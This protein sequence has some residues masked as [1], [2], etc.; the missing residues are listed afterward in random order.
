MLV[1]AAAPEGPLR[2]SGEFAVAGRDT[3]LALSPD[4]NRLV[5]RRLGDGGEPRYWVHDLGQS[6]AVR[7]A[8]P[9]FAAA[10]GAVW[11]LDATFLA[12]PC[13]VETGGG[14]E[15]R[16]ALAAVDGS[17]CGHLATVARF[18][19]GPGRVAWLPGGPLAFVGSCRPMTWD[20]YL[21]W[22]TSGEEWLAVPGVLAD[23][24]AVH[25]EGRR[26]AYS[27]AIRP[28]RVEI[29]DLAT[30][31][32]VEVG[33]YG[34]GVTAALWSPDGGRLAVV[35]R[36]HGSDLAAVS[37]YEAGSG[38]LVAGTGEIAWVDP[39]AGNQV[40]WSAGGRHV[41]LV[42]GVESGQPPKAIYRVDG[43]TGEVTTWLDLTGG[44]G[45]DRLRD[46]RATL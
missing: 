38:V 16:I 4:G 12:I 8:L 35:H 11:S 34:A 22:V 40:A 44:E 41:F 29:A 26:V 5:T 13:L 25:P 24:L 43:E 45:E 3:H 32:R 30:G 10:G 23:G 27:T 9:P 19:Y 39:V 20:I 37:V 17:Y 46:L 6:T 2:L 36:R 28:W 33:R 42:G 14:L 1:H 18:S 7:L 21:H 15:G 31:E